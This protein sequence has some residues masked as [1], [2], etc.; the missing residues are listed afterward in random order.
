[1]VLKVFMMHYSPQTHKHCI[2]LVSNNMRD[3]CVVHLCFQVSW[4][5]ILYILFNW[6]SNMLFK[7]SHSSFLL[8]DDSMF[9][10]NIFLVMYVDLLYN[11]FLLG[12]IWGHTFLYYCSIN[13]YNES[14][15]TFFFISDRSV[16]K[17][18]PLC[19]QVPT[20]TIYQRTFTC[21]LLPC[22]DWGLIWILRGAY[23]D[24]KCLSDASKI[25]FLFLSQ[26][27]LC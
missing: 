13:Y 8:F 25:F 21:I 11:K 23:T 22:N 2:F 12:C 26:T 1:M 4:L 15:M 17:H 3:N 10:Y 7:R 16:N 18:S 19:Y 9:M 20:W 6:K 27:V 24:A 14:I 5:M